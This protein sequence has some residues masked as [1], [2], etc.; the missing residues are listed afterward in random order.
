[1]PE[2]SARAGKEADNFSGFGPIGMRRTGFSRQSGNASSTVTLF[3]FLVANQG[4]GTYF[5]CKPL[6]SRDLKAAPLCAMEYPNQCCFLI[7]P[8]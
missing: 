3:A 5:A 2:R 8:S 6:K 7:T 4:F 1:M